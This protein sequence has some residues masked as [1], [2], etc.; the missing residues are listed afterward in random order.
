MRIEHSGWSQEHGP[1]RYFIEIDENK[2]DYELR[3]KNGSIAKQDGPFHHATHD[4]NC[5]GDV[6]TQFGAI[7]QYF[8]K[9]GEPD[10][11]CFWTPEDM[12]SALVD[13]QEKPES[14]LS[15]GDVISIPGIEIPERSKRPN[16]EDTIIRSERRSEAQEIERNRKMA[17]LGIRHPDEPWAK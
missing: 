12:V 7:F 3:F 14:R 16:L 11:R 10:G 1:F 17:A 5:D 13:A 15:G 9:N 2:T 6:Y 4:W 8:D